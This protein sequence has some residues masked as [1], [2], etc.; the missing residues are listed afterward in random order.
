MQDGAAK[1]QRVWGV[2]LVRGRPYYGYTAGDRV[3]VKIMMLSPP[4]VLKAAALLQVHTHTL[5]A[6]LAPSAFPTLPGSRARNSAHD[7][8]RTSHS[9]EKVWNN[10]FPGYNRIF[11]SNLQTKK[12]P[13]EAVTGCLGVAGG[14]GNGTQVPAL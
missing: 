1:R 11:Q 3:F 12:R 7:S 8:V 6:R 9:A 14:C 5:L 13:M 4:D 2:V 10:V